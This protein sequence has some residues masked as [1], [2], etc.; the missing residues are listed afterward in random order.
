MLV[1]GALLAGRYRLEELLGRGGMATVY[2]AVDIRLHREVAVKVLAHDQAASA[3]A[4]ERF[5]REARAMA[6]LSHPAIV[7]IFDVEWS[8]PGGEHGPF[9]VMELV[10]GGTFA[11]RLATEGRL[12]PGEVADLIDRLASALAAMHAAGLVHRDVKPHNILLGPSGP[13]LADLGVVRLTDPATSPASELTTS[14]TTLGTLRYLAP[15]VLHGA[16]AGPA[17]DTFALAMVAF[18]ALTGR[19]PRPTATLGELIDVADHPAPRVSEAAPGLGERYDDVFAAALDPDPRNRTDVVTFAS[20]L[21]RAVAMSGSR[22]ALAAAPSAVALADATTELVPTPARMAPGGAARRRAP[23]RRGFRAMAA[24]TLIATLGLVALGVMASGLLLPGRDASPRVA[25]GPGTDNAA[26]T[27][28]GSSPSPSA[29]PPPT[30]TAPPEPTVDLVEAALGD[31]RVAIEGAR[32]GGGLKGNETND[33][34]KDVAEI[35]R[36]LADGK[37][38][39]AGELARKLAD[40]VR[41]LVD[42][43]DVE[44]ADGERLLAAATTLARLLPGG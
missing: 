44:G 32:G 16:P 18:L 30:P 43:G 34:L 17:A 20:G 40:R 22:P 3:T 4:A 33:L 38:D 24:L 9:L 12:D 7:P 42:K 6:A 10:S 39:K 23:A 2:R 15:E 31:L 36:A 14:D 21:R 29:T 28:P 19:S 41:G 35:E 25:D 1:P 26:T 8:A 37:L 11:E 13:K 27:L 5:L